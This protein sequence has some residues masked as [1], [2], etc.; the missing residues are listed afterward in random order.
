MGYIQAVSLAFVGF[1]FLA[2]PVVAQSPLDSLPQC[3]V[4]L[5]CAFLSIPG[6][7]LTVIGYLLSRRCGESD[8]KHAYGHSVYLHKW[9]TQRS[10]T[11][12][13]WALMLGQAGTQ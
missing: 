9:A 3:A 8:S 13:C 7:P 11:D 6:N 10:N 5:L 12:L 4:S 1:S 2:Q